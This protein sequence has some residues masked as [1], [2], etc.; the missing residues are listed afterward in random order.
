MKWTWIKLTLATVL[1]LPLV[2]CRT[3]SRYN[4]ILISLDTL[5]PDHLNT[6]GYSRDTSPFM[7]QFA[8]D[9]VVFEQ[10]FSQSPKTASSHMTIFTGLYPSV[11]RVENLSQKNRGLSDEIPTLATMLS[12]HGYRTEAVV[13]GGNVSGKLGFDRGFESYQET[14]ELRD[15]IEQGERIVERLASLAEP[16]FLFVHTYQVHDPYVPDPEFADLFSDPNYAGE[17]IG[18]R[19]ELERVAGGQEY[20]QQ[21]NAYWS[22]VDP[23]SEADAQ[24]LRDLYD[25]EIRFTDDL[26]ARFFERV[27]E[28]G[29]FSNTVVVVLSDHGEEF[30]EH[31]SALH[32]TLYSEVLHVPLIFHLPDGLGVESGQRRQEIVRLIDIKPTILEILGISTPDHVQGTSLL[33]LMRGRGAASL[34]VFSERIQGAKRFALQI[35]GWKYIRDRDR[36]ELY[37]LRTDPDET[38]NLAG[39][40]EAKLRELRRRADDQVRANESLGRELQPGSSFELEKQTREQLEALGYIGD[41]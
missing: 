36:E 16:F 40:N 12:T 3:E 27:E 38:N 2:S 33:D 7:A 35:D 21:Y 5:R 14:T 37:D 4:L 28:L 8:E 39:R 17:I 31:G 20:W 34:P 10:A 13:G 24:H 30:F 22:R 6:Y 15:P 41:S 29:L 32:N 9:S 19:E 18:S 1:T 23:K 11:H 26:L 25:A